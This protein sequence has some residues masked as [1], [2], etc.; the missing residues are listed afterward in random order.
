MSSWHSLMGATRAWWRHKWAHVLL[1]FEADDV[2]LGSR[3]KWTPALPLSEEVVMRGEST[4]MGG[5]NT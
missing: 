4:W 5:E 3:H 2:Q 1:P